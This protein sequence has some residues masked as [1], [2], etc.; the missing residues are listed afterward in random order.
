[1]AGITNY[2]RED[3][4]NQNIQEDVTVRGDGFLEKV[5]TITQAGASEEDLYELATRSYGRGHSKGFWMG[6]FSGLVLAVT[7]VGAAY[8]LGR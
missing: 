1:M 2:E 7:L 5:V 4:M 3:R 6:V 8:F